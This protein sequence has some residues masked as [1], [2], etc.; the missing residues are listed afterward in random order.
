MVGEHSDSIVSLAYITV[1]YLNPCCSLYCLRTH[2]MIVNINK[3]NFLLK[4]TI[5]Q[6]G[7]RFSAPLMHGFRI[8]YFIF[9]LV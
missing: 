7:K 4:E 6:H 8:D 3:H 5:S 2:N 9:F 1:R